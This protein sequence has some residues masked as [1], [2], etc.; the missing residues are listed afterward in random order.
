M[1]RRFSK[2]AQGTFD[3]TQPPRQ[4]SGAALGKLHRMRCTYD[5][6][7]DGAVTTADEILLGKLPA[8][9]VFAYGVINCSATLATSVIAIGTNA[10]HASNGQYRAAAVQT[11]VDAPAMFGRTPAQIAEP[12][13]APTDVFLT[14]ATANLPGAGTIV[15]DIFYSRT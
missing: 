5:L 13:A 4:Q 2:E 14:V 8:G 11:V 12:L 15:V 9:A 6:A 1:A 7:V 10:V 3:G